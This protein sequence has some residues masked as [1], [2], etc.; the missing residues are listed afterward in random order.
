MQLAH[1]EELLNNSFNYVKL[2]AEEEASIAAC[3]YQCVM[4]DHAENLEDFDHW[5][6]QPAISWNQ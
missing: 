4:F 1:L 6:I 3:E 2:T 5:S